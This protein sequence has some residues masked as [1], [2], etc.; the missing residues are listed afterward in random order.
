LTPRAKENGNQL[1][2][3]VAETVPDHV[4]GDPLRLRQILINLIGNA[5][6][7]TDKGSVTMTVTATP[8]QNGDFML[9]CAIRDT[10][11]GIAPDQQLTLFEPFTQADISMTRRYGGTGLGLTICKHLV[12]LMGGEIGVISA[13]GEGST[14]WFTV[15]FR[16]DVELNARLALQEPPK[17]AAP[18]PANDASTLLPPRTIEAD[19]AD[20][21]E[22][23]DRLAGRKPSGGGSTGG[24]GVT[25]N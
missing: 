20:L 17:P 23:F 18:P 5:I 11:I 22:Q 7:F 8:L 24:G 3:D 2:L 15:R 16:E 6:K 1:I 25:G 13:P 21:V 10:G 19:I 9:H 12:H 14:F 4:I